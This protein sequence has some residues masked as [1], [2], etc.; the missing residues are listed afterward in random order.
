[1]LKAAL[2]VH[3]T[4]SDGEFTL[5]ELKRLFVDE[6]CS[7]VG[8]TAHADSFDEPKLADYVSECAS[9]S[10]ERFLFLCAPEYGCEQRMHI[11]GSG[12]TALWQTED[13]QKA[14]RRI[15]QH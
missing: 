12:T 5:A 2:H 13:P 9:L 8:I 14:I 1:M 3:S 15:A 6:G 11:L 10:A 7:V 4:Y